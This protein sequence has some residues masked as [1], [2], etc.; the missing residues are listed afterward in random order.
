M[1]AIMRKNKDYLETLFG[2]VEYLINEIYAFGEDQSFDNNT[3]ISQEK[4]IYEEFNPT[5]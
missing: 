1:P 3:S 5:K 2:D 4:V